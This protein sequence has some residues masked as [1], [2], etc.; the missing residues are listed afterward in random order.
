MGQEPTARPLPAW[1]RWADRVAETIR[2]QD[3]WRRLRSFD[4]CGPKGTLDGTV[5]VTSFAS[6]DYLGL[7]HHPAV[8]AGAVEA[9]RLWGAGAGS[10]RLIVGHRSLHAALESRL[11]EWKHAESALVFSTGFAANLGVLATLADQ[12]VTIFSDA[13]NHASIID[14]CRLARADVQVF[15]HGDMAHLENLLRRR[16][17]GRALVVS[18]A[19]FSMDGDVAN[20][21]SLM[22]ISFRHGALLVVDEAHAVLPWPPEVED[23]MSSAVEDGRLVRV[24]TLS[25]TLGSLGGFVA[26]NASIAE[27]LV[28]LARPFIFSTALSPPA[29]GA[30]MAALEVV[31][32]PEGEELLS[33]L[34]ANIDALSPTSPSPIVPVVVG[35]EAA[36]L[37]ASARL[38][39]DGFLVP[40][41]RPPTVPKGTS[42]L[43]ISLSSDHS[44][45]QVGRLKSALDA[46]GLAP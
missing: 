42:R 32:S 4:G 24:G 12:E 39:E 14:G 17:S 41:I 45:E 38:L 23:A 3:R 20:L 15:D 27:L 6:N 11:A 1:D 46:M 29:V 34:R 5:E 9:A 33:R 13:L 30:A 44:P 37:E 2:R 22:E 36:A 7:S 40:A 43:R 19:V 25:K 16:R 10:S 35:D 8:V 18:D 26:S 28:N 31:A 21:S